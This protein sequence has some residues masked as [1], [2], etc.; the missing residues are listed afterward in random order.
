MIISETKTSKMHAWMHVGLFVFVS[1]CLVASGNTRRTYL[2]F[3]SCGNFLSPYVVRFG[4]FPLGG[5][6][7]CVWGGREGR[8]GR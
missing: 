7:V 5:W 3:V 8:G 6:M 2:V 4:K 1:P